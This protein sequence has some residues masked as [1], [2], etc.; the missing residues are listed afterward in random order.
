MLYFS[1]RVH[2]P[3]M[4][5]LVRPQATHCALFYKK[6]LLRPLIFSTNI[7]SNYTLF[8]TIAFQWPENDA[9]K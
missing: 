8:N 7:Q 2:E 6:C 4:F 3:I 5:T 1:E 9:F